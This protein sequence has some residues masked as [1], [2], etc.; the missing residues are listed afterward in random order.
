[1]SVETCPL[2][3]DI[4]WIKHG[5]FG[6]DTPFALEKPL[7]GII[8]FSNDFP[9]TVFLS[10]THSARILDANDDLS[11]SADAVMTSQN[12][13]A[14]AIKTADCC[15]VFLV[16]TQTK[17]IANIHAGWRG[18]LNNIVID[19]L[20]RMT[21]NGAVPRNI[22]AA[23]GPSICGVSYPVEDDVRDQFVALQPE[24]LPSFTKT[25]D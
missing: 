10:Q 4:P 23:I 24:A 17:Q 11:V 25:G 21:E 12:N 2:L 18:A 20:A 8:S 5:F 22:I 7:M 13:I 19:T 9:K 15:P 3:Q 1:M 14:L 16:C 6:K